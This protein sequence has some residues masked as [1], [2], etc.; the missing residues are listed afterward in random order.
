MKN[1]QVLI[2]DGLNPF[3]AESASECRNLRRVQIVGGRQAREPERQVGV[4][5]KGVRRLLARLD[6]W[7]TRGAAFADA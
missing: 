1:R 2:G 4:G 5:G 7:H 3:R 6:Y